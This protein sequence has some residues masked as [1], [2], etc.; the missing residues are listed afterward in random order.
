[1]KFIASD[2]PGVIIIEPDVHRDDRGFFLESY[3]ADKY[4]EGGV[5][6]TFVQDNHS[7]SVRGI[8]RGLHMQ[9]RR[10]QGK[11]VR[12]VAG[13][14]FDVAVDV[15]V[16]SPHFGHWIGVTLS[17]EN[18]RQVY[19]PEGF[20]HGFV[21][22]SEVAEFEYKCT[23]FYD[24]GSELSIAWNDPRIGIDWPIEAPVLSAKDA[25]AP[26]LEEVMDR[27]PKFEG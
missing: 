9:L 8:L 22:T 24:P 16:G 2:L 21:V 12:V 6:A 23:N 10:A 27:L 4:R 13:E 1:V 3:H 5:D 19:I 17:A 15:R 18:H 11:L 25:A 14:V 26:R 20:A 7:R